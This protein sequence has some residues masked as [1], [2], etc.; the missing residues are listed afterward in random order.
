MEFMP[1]SRLALPLLVVVASLLSC[2]KKSAAPPPV[3]LAED[4]GYKPL[5]TRNPA[6]MQ[7]L[8]QEIATV[9]AD[10]PYP[11]DDRIVDGNNP[12]DLEAAALAAAFKGKHW[13]QLTPQ[14]LRYHGLA[15]LSPEALHFYLPAYLIGSLYDYGETT[16]TDILP[17]TVLSLTLADG[18]TA[19]DK[20]LRQRDLKR[21]AVFTP[22]QKRAIRSFLEYV[23]DELPEL[24]D[25]PQKA[26]ALYWSRD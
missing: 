4:G 16:Y 5:S 7:A 17:S 18:G 6:R 23:R 11:G 8:R 19:L 12:Y 10:V 9:F 1:R 20:M 14:E 3:P 26:L 22:A 21:V 2:E 25:D 24:G 13:K 15:F